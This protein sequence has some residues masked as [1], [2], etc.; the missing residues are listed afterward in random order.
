MAGREAREY[1]SLPQDQGK[2]WD[3][4]A[5]EMDYLTDTYIYVKLKVLK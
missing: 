5:R 4:D 3:Y 2:I 1:T